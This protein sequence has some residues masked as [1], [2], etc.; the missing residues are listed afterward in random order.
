MGMARGVSKDMRPDYP[1]PP[2]ESSDVPRPMECRVI[3]EAGKWKVPPEER[4]EGWR[5]L[6]VAREKEQNA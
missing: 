3:L 5:K 4:P 6:K 1:I 2:A